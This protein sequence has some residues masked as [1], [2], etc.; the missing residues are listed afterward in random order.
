MCGRVGSVAARLCG[1][2][3]AG[4]A[5]GQRALII[6]RGRAVVISCLRGRRWRR[7]KAAGIVPLA[8]PRAE[9]RRQPAVS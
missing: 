6:P 1:V 5:E 7:A 3:L 8:A 4:C 9:M 2:T